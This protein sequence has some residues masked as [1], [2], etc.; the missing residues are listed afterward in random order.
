MS[1]GSQ[2]IATESVLIA[3]LNRMQGLANYPKFHNNET[4]KASDDC[5][6]VKVTQGLR[7]QSGPLA[8]LATAEVMVRTAERDVDRNNV[9][10]GEIQNG[11]NPPE[12]TAVDGLDE[13]IVFQL[14]PEKMSSIINE[15]QNLRRW[16]ITM[17]LRVKHKVFS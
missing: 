10:Y 5:I 6:V 12:E 14:F 16:K 9:I 13:F 15:T 4:D 7:E 1:D 17:P 2:I 3:L 8:W 11:L